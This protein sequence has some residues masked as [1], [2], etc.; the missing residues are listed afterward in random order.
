MLGVCQ[1][2]LGIWGDGVGKTGGREKEG[3]GARTHDLDDVLVDVAGG[4][5]AVVHQEVPERIWHDDG[6][7]EPELATLGGGG[8]PLH[9][10]CPGIVPGRRGRVHAFKPGRPDSS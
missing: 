6:L 9:C 10:F 5:V 2:L 4:N 1:W 3:G 7:V 8:R